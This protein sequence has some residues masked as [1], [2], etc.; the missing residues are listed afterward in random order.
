M[1][2]N[3]YGKFLN[4]LLNYLQKI[5]FK[6]NFFEKTNRKTNFCV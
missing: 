4:N 1:K 2:N 5:L 3:K 6:E